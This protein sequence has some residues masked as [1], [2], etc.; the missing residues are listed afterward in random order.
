[1]LRHTL[2]CILNNDAKCR[3]QI[4]KLLN[5]KNKDIKNI[6]Q[7]SELYVDVLEGSNTEL[8]NNTVA[9]IFLACVPPVFR[10]TIVGNPSIVKCDLC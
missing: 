6:K 8:Y 9:F 7:I 4:L 2:N 5:F 3:L 1:M 10:R